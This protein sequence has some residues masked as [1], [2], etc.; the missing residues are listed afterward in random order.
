MAN[1]VLREVAKNIHETS[2]D[3]IKAT[4]YEG[5]LVVKTSHD[6]KFRT[7]DADTAKFLHHFFINAKKSGIEE[8]TQKMKQQ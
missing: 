8:F 3:D 6:R 4:V 1:P 7:D 5:E 2:T